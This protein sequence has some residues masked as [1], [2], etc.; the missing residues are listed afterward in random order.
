MNQTI[1]VAQFRRADGAIAIAN[2]A[3]A[4]RRESDAEGWVL[5]DYM[6]KFLLNRMGED[7]A[8]GIGIW[9]TLRLLGA[10]NSDEYNTLFQFVMYQKV[11]PHTTAAEFKAITEALEMRPQDRITNMNLYRLESFLGVRRGSLCDM[12]RM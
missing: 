11:F 10:L 12:G 8:D 7:G 5:V 9:P 6:A 3:S 2:L 1:S 4:I